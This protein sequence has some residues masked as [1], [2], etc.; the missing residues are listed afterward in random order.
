LP[1]FVAFLVA[2]AGCD[3]SN[4]F[5]P[6]NNSPVASDPGIGEDTPLGDESGAQIIPLDGTVLAPASFAG[7]IPFGTSNQPYTALGGRYNGSLDVLW[8]EDLMRVLEG[9]RARG[10]KVMLSM[11]GNQQYW[12]DAQGHFSFTKWKERV[13]RY[14]GMNFSSYIADGTLMGHFL[15]DEPNDPTNW[16]GERVSSSM[17]EQMAKYS[18]QLWPTLPTIARA[19]PNYLTGSHPYL[20][21]AWA[22]YVYRKGDVVEFIRRHV[23]DAQK[24][25]LALVVGL[26]MIRGGPNGSMM[27]ASQ[28][29]SW[30][31]TLLSN[32]YPCAFLSYQWNSNY[33]SSP[34]IQDAMDYLRNKAQSR[35]S[36]S[37][38]GS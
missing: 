3:N 4:S 13:D 21:A 37:C 26:N 8:P 22:Q 11:V 15:I 30:G 28:V 6:D 19:E 35:S 16:N 31:G 17:V 9:S 33:L 24:L 20:D 1:V 10:G 25:G 12:V 14:K 5:S 27:T 23:A 38:R 29:K 2:F 36:K 7:G 34:S 18:K 32:S